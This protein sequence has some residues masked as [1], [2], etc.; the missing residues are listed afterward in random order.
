M[1]LPSRCSA[2][3]AEPHSPQNA[4][5]DPPGGAQRRMRSSPWTIRTEPRGTPADTEEP[6][7]VR[8]WQRVQWQ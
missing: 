8:R 3:S 6:P 1:P 5:G 2:H 7:P 4:F